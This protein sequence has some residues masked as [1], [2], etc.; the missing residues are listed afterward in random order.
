[1]KKCVSMLL[2]ICMLVACMVTAVPSVHAAKV[3]PK[4]EIAIVF[5]N[6]GS[7][8]YDQANKDAE[9][10]L[11]SDWC[12]ATYAMEVFASM[13]NQGDTLTI[14]PMWPI[15]IGSEKYSKDNPLKIT[16]SSQSSKIREIY[17]PETWGTP[18]EPI[19][20]A[21]EKLKA[22][23]ADEKY[24]V[25]LTDGDVFDG[26][27]TETTPGALADRFK[28][29]AGPEITV[30]YLG[31]GA[32]AADPTMDENEY[33]FKK[34]AKDSAD[35]LSSL[36]VMCNQIFGRDTLPADY[37]K[38]NNIE[39]DIS[40]SKVIV[41]VQGKDISGLKVTN[42]SG[43]PMGTQASSATTSYSTTKGSGR[44]K[45]EHGTELPA[46][47]VKDTSLQGMMVTY[48]GCAA[49]QYKI[50]YSGTA[51]SVEV[52]YEPAADLSFVFTDADDNPVD[53]KEL[54]EGSYK[55]TYGMFD[56]ETG[57]FITDSKLLGT[58]KYKGSY[59]I[60]GEE[61]TFESEGLSGVVEMELKMNDTFEANLTATYLSGYTIRKDS[62]DFGW[63]E[64]GITVAARPAGDLKLEITGGQDKYMLQSLEQG[65]PY[66]I[67]VFY[68]GTQ[69]TG[70]ELKKVELTW[71]DEKGYAAL[72]PTFAE[73]HYKLSLHHKD[74]SAPQ[75]TKAGKCKI[76]INASYAAPGSDTAKAKRNLSYE[77]DKNESVLKME[78]IA[79]QSYIVIKE[80]ASSE[81]ITVKLTINGKPLTAEE[82]ARVSLSVS[83][84]QIK[85]TITPNPD[86]STFT[87][88]LGA[89]EGVAEGKYLIEASA[90]YTDA[91]GRVTEAKGGARI[92]L[93][94]T[95]RWIKWLLT[96][97]GIL[98][99]IIIVWL[100]S[101]IKA[102]PK[103]VRAMPKDSCFLSLAGKNCTDEPSTDFKAKRVK[104]QVRVQLSYIT[105]DFF[106][107]MNRIKPGQD[108]CVFTPQRKRYFDVEPNGVSI[109]GNITSLSIAGISYVVDK[110]GVLAPTDE[111]QTAFSVRDGDTISMSGI[112]EINGKP[113]KFNSDIQITFK[114][115][116]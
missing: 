107:R 113:K 8:Y 27:T 103:T 108:S 79:P 49:G 28:K 90:S 70:E 86:K 35:V 78:L 7:M 25:V 53:P 65:E 26:Y 44:D 92:K 68:K 16:D 2:V 77:I 51:N 22:A 12:R 114:K 42:G 9:I 17:S 40:M 85:H 116:K 29:I 37:I 19:D 34:L 95:A 82:F 94:N 50:E 11:R 10:T 52:Y 20:L 63:P 64:G 100:I 3:T 39:F 97:G 71:D 5:D 30:M 61:K 67:K 72:K 81:P 83:C 36:T 1:M 104:K 89:T 48:T 88:K 105:D 96:I 56:S 4:R 59:I 109:I 6:S 66:I 74:P 18:I 60:N 75:N 43:S 15:E 98:A 99:L 57:D 24:L 69:L 76:A 102:L 115:K 91:I 47:K 87:I 55:V 73:D 32:V 41:F 31:I 84:D 14:Y 62:T 13:L 54:Y 23:T 45:T 106:V 110:N 101:R 80:L 33:F 93:S 112:I 21:A 111:T 46:E 58:P 38:G